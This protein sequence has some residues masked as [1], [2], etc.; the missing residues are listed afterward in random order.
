[1]SQT[2]LKC[3]NLYRKVNMY[4][5][6]YNGPPHT[7]QLRHLADREGP[8]PIGG[9]EVLGY[10]G[11]HPKVLHQPDDNVVRNFPNFGKYLIS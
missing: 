4:P 5:P 2:Q 9:G 11:V 8:V 3:Q 6:A 10:L 1:M 7:S